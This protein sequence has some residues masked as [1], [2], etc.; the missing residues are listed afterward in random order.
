MSHATTDEYKLGLLKHVKEQFDG[1]RQVEVEG[2][3]TKPSF[4]NA[5]VLYE[6]ISFERPAVIILTKTDY[7]GLLYDADW[8][9]IF[10]PEHLQA[11]LL[12]GYRGKLAGIDVLSEKGTGWPSVTT[13]AGLPNVL[14]VKVKGPDVP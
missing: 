5:C 6:K 8:R 11:P 12:A 13:L 10:E 7:F 3:F 2:E 4:F 1:L 9:D 14:T